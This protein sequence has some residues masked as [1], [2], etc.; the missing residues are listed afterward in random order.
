V[1]ARLLR[2]LTD[3][4]SLLGR[5]RTVGERSAPVVLRETPPGT[6][7]YVSPLVRPVTRLLPHHVR[8]VESDWHVAPAALESVRVG[9]AMD[10]ILRGTA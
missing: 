4:T 3:E 8:R 10:R 5:I 7:V 1:F 2:Q 6:W 9:L